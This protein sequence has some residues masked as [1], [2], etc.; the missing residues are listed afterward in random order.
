MTPFF[1]RKRELEILKRYLKKQTASLLVIRGRRRIGKSRLAM[2][3]GKHFKTYTFSGL[4]PD[5]DIKITDQMQRD[6]FGRQLQREV[7]ISGIKTDDW[8]DLFW[9]LSQKVKRGRILIILDEITWMG[10]KDATF[11]GK[12]KNAWDLYFKSNPKLVI[13]LS[14]SVSGWIEKNILSST[15]FLGRISFDM[16]LEEL[17]LHICNQFWGT[18]KDYISSYEKFKTLSVTG[19]VPRYLEEIDPDLS[20][21]ENIHRLAF[22]KGSILFKEFERIFSDLFS[23]RTE[24]YKR[25]VKTMAKGPQDL[26]SICDK[27]RIKKGGEMSHCL[28]DLIET[29]YVARDFTW[30]LKDGKKSELSRYRLK[31]NY[32]RFYLKYIEPNKSK[33]ETEGSIKPPAWYTIMGL[34]FVNLVINNRRNLYPIIGISPDDVL[35]AN[36]YFQKKTLRHP[37]CQIDFMIQSKFNTLYLCEIKFSK[38]A[39]GKQVIDEVKEKIKNLNVSRQ[40]SIRPV[41][42]HVNGV[43]QSVVESNF[44]SHIIDFSEFFHKK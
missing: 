44:F 37:G 31:D 4:P 20:A 33:I 34:Q 1:G 19:G 3:F 23:K 28:E 8:G 15:G 36:S 13:I 41:L 40:F 25:I 26:N 10:S 18:N 17:P 14:G 30:N 42:I 12:L 6:E 29:G 43:N 35:I 24:K 11:L 27:L 16:V 38:E 39:I 22:Q 32:L 9:N 21:E 2:E 5:D 7:G